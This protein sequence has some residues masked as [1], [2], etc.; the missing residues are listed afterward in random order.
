MQGPTAMPALDSPE[1]DRAAMLGDT[2]SALVAV[3]TLLTFGLYLPI[4][5]LTR[6]R[7]LNALGAPARVDRR[8]VLAMLCIYGINSSGL[9][10]FTG[11]TDMQSA[12]GLS[13]LGH[14]LTLAS[15]MM[16]VALRLRVR[17]ILLDRY[18]ERFSPRPWASWVASAILGEIYLQARMNRLPY[19]GMVVPAIPRPAPAQPS[20]L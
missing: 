4:W 6:I 19:F 16:L 11:G 9:L 7:T 3:Y 12:F 2:S 17:V 15:G 18:G 20:A 10:S 13:I 14:V 8:L 5:Y 1:A